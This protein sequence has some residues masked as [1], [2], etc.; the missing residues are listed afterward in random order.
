MVSHEQT[1][2]AKSTADTP[3]DKY[4][5]RRVDQGVFTPHDGYVGE[6]GDPDRPIK[7]DPAAADKANQPRPHYSRR[8]G[9]AFPEVDE[10]DFREPTAHE[11]TPEEREA[12]LEGLDI[13][14]Q[15]ARAKQLR[16]AALS[17][18]PAETRRILA[19]QRARDERRGR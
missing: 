13:A 18:D 6:Y 19:I 11:S 12:N 3:E 4:V 16:N 14:R 7:R 9:R 15:I 1:H 5:D 10:P 8:G 2:I 17:S